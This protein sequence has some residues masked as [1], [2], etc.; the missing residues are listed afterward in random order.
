MDMD[1][2]YRT[3]GGHMLKVLYNSDPQSNYFLLKYK[4][5][6]FDCTIETLAGAMGTREV[7]GNF[8]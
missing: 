2:G 7:A 6:F 1:D 8:I 3:R 5:I 4:L